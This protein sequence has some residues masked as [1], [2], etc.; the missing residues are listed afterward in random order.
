MNKVAKPTIVVATDKDHAALCT[1]D[2][3]HQAV[4]ENS[5][6]V[7]GLATGGTPVGV[8]R[9]LVERFQAGDLDFSDLTTFNLDEYVGLAPEHDQSYRYFMQ[10]QLF[11]HVNVNRERTHVPNGLATDIEIHVAEYEKQILQAG[12]IDLQLLG[13]GNNGHIAFNEPGSAIDSRTR[14]VDLTD[15]TI[16]ANSRFFN[17]AA[18]VPRHA[19]TMG[20]GTILEARR[21]VLMATGESKA[22][23]VQAAIEGPAA[24]R[25]PASLLQGHVGLTFVLDPASAHLLRI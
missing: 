14:Q 13:I 22:K 4:S 10:Q 24:P 9:L 11:D 17:S 8:Y 12:G 20:I 15:D 3:I 23:V 18:D 7:L 19:I 25:N 2:L 1:A 6:A 16:E 5:S 21:I